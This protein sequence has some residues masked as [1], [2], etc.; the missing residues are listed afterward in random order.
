VFRL[1]VADLGSSSYFVATAAVVLGFFAEE[2]IDMEPVIGSDAPEQNTKTVNE[3]S[4]HFFAGPAYDPLK[5]FPGFKG[6]KLLC[7]LAQ[8]SY[9]CMGVRKDIDISRGDLKALSGLRISS[10]QSSPGQGLRHM[11]AQAGIDLERDGIQIV[12]SPS[13]GKHNKF[14]ATDGLVALQS[15]ISDAFWGNAL[16]LEIAVRAGVAKPHIDLRR[17]DGPPGARY[18]NFPALAASEDF[19]R[20]NPEIAAGAVRAIAKTQKALRAEPS[21]ATKVGREVFP[22][23]EA[24]VIAT[25]VERDAPF[26]QAGISHEAVDGL[27]RFCVARQLMTQAMPYDQLIATQLRPLWNS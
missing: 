2:G 22:D 24:E 5:T 23:Q 11:L 16:R 15:G 1:V 12:K 20:E 3:G 27:N 14:R 17:G 13:T 9:W 7:S 6:A 18:Y 8:Y 4:A 10:S 25:L 26:Y 21:L 19:V